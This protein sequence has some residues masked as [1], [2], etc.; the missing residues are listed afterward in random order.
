M[1]RLS[2][3]E[4]DSRSKAQRLNWLEDERLKLTLADLE[5]R[6]RTVRL[7]SDHEQRRIERRFD[8]MLTATRRRQT[9]LATM[10]SPPVSSESTQSIVT[11]GTNAN[12]RSASAGTT[13]STTTAYFTR[14]NGRTSLVYKQFGRGSDADNGSLKREC[15]LASRMT[16]PAVGFRCATRTRRCRSCMSREMSSDDEVNTLIVELGVAGT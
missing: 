15:S 9:P 7:S 13:R 1:S 6:C 16:P 2:F 3:Y 5:R 8:R 10:T 11:C 14:S 4:F 12:A